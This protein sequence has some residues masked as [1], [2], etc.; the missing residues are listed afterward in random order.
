MRL[1][2]RKIVRAR[3]SERPEDGHRYELYDLAADP[4][5]E[6]DLFPKAGGSA[7]DLQKLLDR[8]EATAKELHKK[9]G[10]PADGPTTIDPDLREKLE[11]LGYLDPAGPAAT[12]LG[13]GS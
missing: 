13:S 3:V 5:E 1:G 7:A 6:I 4:R 11:A 10:E 8:Y 9:L 12:S 2:D